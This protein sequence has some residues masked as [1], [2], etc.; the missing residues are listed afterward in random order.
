M[1]DRGRYADL[2][3]TD[4]RLERRG[5]RAQ[6]SGSEDQPLGSQRRMAT[7]T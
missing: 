1:A 5:C 4:L 2:V 6:V 3:V 7:L